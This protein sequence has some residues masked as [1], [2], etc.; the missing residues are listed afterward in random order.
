MHLYHTKCMAKICKIQNGLTSLKNS[1]CTSCIQCHCFFPYFQK[2]WFFVILWSS[3]KIAFRFNENVSGLRF[4]TQTFIVYSKVLYFT[5][6][7]HVQ[8]DKKN[9]CFSLKAIF[10][11]D[12]NSFYS[13][14]FCILIWFFSQFPLV[15]RLILCRLPF[16]HNLLKD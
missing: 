13:L 14:R 6:L 10:F 1:L 16:H 4:L 8:I 3:T 7:L 11:P 9:F 5:L 15:A 12:S 2:R